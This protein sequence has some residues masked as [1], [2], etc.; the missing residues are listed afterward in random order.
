MSFCRIC[1]VCVLSLPLLLASFA[2]HADN[3]RLDIGIST[4]E[5]AITSDFAGADLTV[6]GALDNADRRFAF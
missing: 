5:I 2:A 1:L 4:N 3:E 6:F